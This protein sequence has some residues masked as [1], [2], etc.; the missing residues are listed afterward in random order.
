MVTA[1]ASGAGAG[2]GAGAA[3]V[4][5]FVSSV[6]MSFVVLVRRRDLLN[7]GST[8]TFFPLRKIFKL[9]TPTTYAGILD[10]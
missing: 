8:I 9:K 5:G 7:D 2:A 4:P 3:G 10:L 1:G 6:M